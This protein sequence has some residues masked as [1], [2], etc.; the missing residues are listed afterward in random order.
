[1][2]ARVTKLIAAMPKYTDDDGTN[3]T[4]LC[5]GYPSLGLKQKRDDP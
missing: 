1:M 4:G 3:H 5:V 2:S